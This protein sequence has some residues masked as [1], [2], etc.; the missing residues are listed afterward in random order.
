MAPEHD[1]WYGCDLLE[2]ASEL[3]EE[4][5]KEYGQSHR[6]TTPSSCIADIP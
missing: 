2:D 1:E 5:E 3:V 6:L 4:Y